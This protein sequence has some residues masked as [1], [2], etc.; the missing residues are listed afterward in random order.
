MLTH[1]CI[2]TC[3]Y[4]QICTNTFMC[5]CACL[6][7]R[8]YMH[9]PHAQIHMIYLCSMHMHHTST[10][11]CTLL[12]LSTCTHALAHP[13]CMHVNGYTRETCNAYATQAQ[14]CTHAKCTSTCQHI[15]AHTQTCMRSNNP[16]VCTPTLAHVHM[17]S[18]CTYEH[19]YKI[20]MHMCTCMRTQYTQAYLC[21][22]T[23]IHTHVH[24]HAPSTTCKWARVPFKKLSPQGMHDISPQHG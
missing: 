9:N 14:T 4:T 5:V 22:N 1:V 8:M 20:H 19:D 17:K 6:Y 3:V 7:T 15:C 10:P 11:R 16:H 21:V 13:K 18:T 2:N 23:C 24:T 12:H